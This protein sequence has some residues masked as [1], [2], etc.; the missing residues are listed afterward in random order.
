MLPYLGNLNLSN[1]SETTNALHIRLRLVNSSVISLKV[2]LSTNEDRNKI[3][4]I[5]LTSIN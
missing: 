1:G 2:L 4:A 3:C 5:H